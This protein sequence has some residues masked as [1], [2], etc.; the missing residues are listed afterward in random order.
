MSASLPAISLAN[1]EA[2]LQE[3]HSRSVAIQRLERLDVLSAEEEALLAGLK[4]QQASEENQ[5]LMAA[6]AFRGCSIYL[7]G[8]A[9]RLRQALGLRPAEGP[10]PISGMASMDT[11]LDT[12]NTQAPWAHLAKLARP[13]RMRRSTAVNSPAGCR[14]AD[15]VEAHR[16]ALTLSPV[17]DLDII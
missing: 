12:E 15:T 6:S 5:L 14:P 3:I 11:S 8:H 13:E 1:V 9:W 2:K 16:A 17:L 7:L 4:F 10:L